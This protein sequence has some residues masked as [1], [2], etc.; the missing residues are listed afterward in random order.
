MI[1]YEF[2]PDKKTRY[3]KLDE[4]L[5]PEV[6]SSNQEMISTKSDK[7]RLLFL[8]ILGSTPISAFINLVSLV[9]GFFTIYGWIETR[10]DQK[11]QK[12]A[13]KP[14]TGGMVEEWNAHLEDLNLKMDDTKRSL[15]EV[16]C[17]LDTVHANR[18]SI[19][20]D[21]LQFIQPVQRYNSIKDASRFFINTRTNPYHYRYKKKRIDK[22]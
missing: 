1:F 10:D 20:Q 21:C 22:K 19:N 6:N 2:Y 3:A 14:E 15:K 12:E 9:S 16:I 11:E 13:E 4:D 17:R 7:K 8:G 18:K 5:H